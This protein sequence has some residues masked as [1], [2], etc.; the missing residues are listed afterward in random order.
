MPTAHATAL[1]L[2]PVV[3]DVP[4]GP[5]SSARTLNTD[6]LRSTPPRQTWSRPPASVAPGT[7][8]V[9]SQRPP[10]TPAVPFRPPPPPGLHGL[11]PSAPDPDAVRKRLRREL[12]LLRTSDGWVVLGVPHDAAP[13][14]IQAAGERMRSRYQ[15]IADASTGETQE[16]ALA[17]LRRVTEALAGLVAM[18]A[19]VAGES[20]EEP[21]DDAFRSGLRAMAQGD[22][23]IAD[24]RFVA[25]RDQNL[26]S[27]RN[28]AHLGWARAHNTEYPADERKAEG[29]DLLRLAEQFAPEYAEGQ[30]FLAMLLH[31]AGDG[32]GALRR[33]RRALKA[34]PDH[35]GAGGLAR[36]LRRPVPP[37]R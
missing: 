6:A 21:G 15:G 16:L 19:P 11:P 32:E 18:L 13:E 36:K 23:A 27:A 31:Q 10:A 12:D 9:A 26:D 35:V 29:M 1:G 14:M 25:A 7:P 30:Y 34:E 20:R 37:P 8:S 5:M 4:V 2:T 3:E 28:L 33:L 17:M 24:R 22:W